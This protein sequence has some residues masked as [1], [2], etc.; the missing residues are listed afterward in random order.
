MFTTIKKS[1]VFISTLVILFVISAP[2]FTIA[3]AEEENEDTQQIKEFNSTIE[4]LLADFKK[5][6]ESNWTANLSDYTTGGDDEK[7]IELLE[8]LQNDIEILNEEIEETEIND[9]LGWG[10]KRNVKKIKKSFSKSFKKVDKQSDKLIKKIKKGKEIKVPSLKYV[11]RQINKAD[12]AYSKLNDNYDTEIK[13]LKFDAPEKIE[14]KIDKTEK[15][16]EDAKENDNEKVESDK[17]EEDNS[18]EKESL[19]IEEII[20]ADNPSIKKATFEDGYLRLELD[21][22]G[23]FSVNTMFSYPA[24]D[25]LNAMGIAFK[26]DQVETV[27][28][29][30]TGTLMDKKGN[31]S[32]EDLI[33]IY[34]NR[35]NFEEFDFDNFKIMSLSEPWRIYN[36]S[37][38]YFIH[39]AIYKDLKEKYISNLING[40]SKVEFPD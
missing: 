19:T 36:E 11:E 5:T 18:N 27:G 8:S 33:S 3:N 22:D 9:D 38:S 29:I 4:D 23:S 20:V 2:P 10:Q 21:G 30:V 25:A 13:E 28:A 17:K 1:F 6:V 34:Y 39:P 35:S 14:K 24:N 32:K 40:N 31:E 7:T 12:K 26:D 15:H 16:S 37:D